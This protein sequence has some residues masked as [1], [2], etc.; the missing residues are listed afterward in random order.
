MS[1]NNFEER[2]EFMLEGIS[3]ILGKSPLPKPEVSGQPCDHDSDGF[4]YDE[5]PMY[6]LLTCSRCGE[7]YEKPKI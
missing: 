1:E 2:Q 3:Q 5:T 6:V 7:Q 4:I